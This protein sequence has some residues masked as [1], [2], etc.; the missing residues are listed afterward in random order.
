MQK[1]Q[2]PTITSQDLIRV[3]SHIASRVEAEKDRL[4]A[5]DGIG[6]GDHGVTMTIGFRAV[7]KSLDSLNDTVTIDQV[8]RTAGD[9]FLLSAGGAI[10]PLLGTM[11]TDTGKAFTGRVTFGPEE[12]VWMLEIMEQALVKRGKAQL[13]NKTMLD[14]LHPAV[15]AAQKDGSQGLVEILRTAADAADTG[16]RATSGMMS[17]LGRSSRLAERTLG[18]EDAGANSMALVLRAMCEAV[19]EL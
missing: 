17:A 14:A 10:G 4:N 18:H 2:R 19:A 7:K 15:L 16:A 6:D 8:F 12:I 13:G 1:T 3:F 11:L 9:A 5:L